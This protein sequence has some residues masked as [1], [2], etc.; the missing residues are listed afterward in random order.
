[1]IA[2]F[3]AGFWGKEGG[4]REETFNNV[5]TVAMT[6]P[7]GLSESF[8]PLQ[9]GLSCGGLCLSPT[10]VVVQDRG[11]GGLVTVVVGENCHDVNLELEILYQDWYK[12]AVNRSEDINTLS[13]LLMLKWH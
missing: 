10:P 7:Q 2:D 4:K 13:M 12:P 8:W 1:M 9:G 6:P 11:S 3:S 5:E